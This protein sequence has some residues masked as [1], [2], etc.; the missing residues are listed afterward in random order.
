VNTGRTARVAI[1]LTFAGDVLLSGV[2]LRKVREPGL[3]WRS[4]F[5]TMTFEVRPR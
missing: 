4:D 2:N 3:D 1:P 5:T